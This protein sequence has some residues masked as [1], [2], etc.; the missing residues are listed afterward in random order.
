LNFPFPGKTSRNIDRHYWYTIKQIIFKPMAYQSLVKPIMTYGHPNW[1]Q[2]SIASQCSR[3]SRSERRCIL[4]TAAN[5]RP[6]SKQK[7]VAMQYADLVSFM[8]FISGTW[9]RITE[10]QVLR[11][12]ATNSSSGCQLKPGFGRMPSPFG[13]VLLWKALWPAR[14]LFHALTVLASLGNPYLFFFC[15]FI[16]HSCKCHVKMCL[17]MN[18]NKRKIIKLTFN[19]RQ[20]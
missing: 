16:M 10:G 13:E 17:W 2:P 12:P 5:L 11:G 14:D 6:V 3:D 4:S 9:A 15:Y 20:N 18:K 7:P 19:W 8:C 1:H